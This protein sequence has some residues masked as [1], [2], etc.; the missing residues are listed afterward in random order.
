VSTVNA[1]GHPLARSILS[2]VVDDR[3]RVKGVEAR[4][5]PE[6]S[7]NL[8]DETLPRPAS[9]TH[10]YNGVGRRPDN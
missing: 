7:K 8:A 3:L 9:S 1:I 4:F 10:R 6:L 5:D 2:A